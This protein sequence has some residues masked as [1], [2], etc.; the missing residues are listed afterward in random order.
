MGFFGE[1][2]EAMI[3]GVGRGTA[4]PW[5]TYF[6]SPRGQPRLDHVPIDT[7]KWFRIEAILA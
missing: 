1:W 4:F 6:G 7:L 2:D 3:S 5:T